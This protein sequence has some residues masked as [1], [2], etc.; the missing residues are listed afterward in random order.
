M[1]AN[2][3]VLLGDS[4][5]NVIVRG[6]RQ[7]G[8]LELQGGTLF[9]ARGF[10][11]RFFEV[12]D[13]RLWMDADKIRDPLKAARYVEQIGNPLPTGT[14]LLVRMGTASAVFYGNQ[15]WRTYSVAATGGKQH[16]SAQVVD[17]MVQGQEAEVLRFVEA[18]RDCGQ[19]E[20]VIEAPAPQLRHQAVRW[21]GAEQVL[22]LDERYRR[23]MR[24]WC[25][26]NGV[27][28]IVADET[29]GDNGF[30]RKAYYGDNWSH[31]NQRWGAAV[32]AN[33]LAASSASVA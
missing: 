4:H 11:T 12:R 25:R 15:M 33:L 27:R 5:S 9:S 14:R 1:R 23:P 31:A 17:A 10:H 3:M 16:V 19:L 13:G 8:Q 26:E 2:P 32:I 28:L 18:A 20:A 21:L 24:H 7:A 6:A 22:W 30:L 29:I